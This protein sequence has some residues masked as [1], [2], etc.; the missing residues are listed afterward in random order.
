MVKPKYSGLK[1]TNL[2][3]WLHNSQSS[4]RLFNSVGA[5]VIRERAEQFGQL[6]AD[7]FFFNQTQR[8]LEFFNVLAGNVSVLSPAR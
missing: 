4:V 3:L 2:V 5:N 6:Q 7:Q 8:L 1:H